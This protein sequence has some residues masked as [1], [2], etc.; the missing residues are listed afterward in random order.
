MLTAT[1]GLPVWGATSNQGLGRDGTHTCRSAVADSQEHLVVQGAAVATAL[2]AP[3]CAL[4]RTEAHA[5]DPPTSATRQQ[6]VHV[7]S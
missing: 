7:L 4:H 5:S 6:Q 1:F 2:Q 3:R